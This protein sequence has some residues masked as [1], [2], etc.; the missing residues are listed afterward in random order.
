MPKVNEYE[1][2]IP[3]FYR[4]RTLD[5]LLFAHVTAL[6]ERHCMPLE[7]AIIDFM[8]LYKIDEDEYPVKS[9]LIIYHR[10]RNNFIWA[11][12]KEKLDSTSNKS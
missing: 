11:N 6:H 9:A 5:I 3:A 4:K 1:G 12:I 10:V 7:E 2:K 8:G